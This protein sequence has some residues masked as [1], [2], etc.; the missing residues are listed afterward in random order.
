MVSQRFAGLAITPEDNGDTLLANPIVDQAALH[1][2]L[3]TVRDPGDA[4]GRGQRGRPGSA[5]A[6]NAD[7]TTPH[8]INTIDN[9]QQGEDAHVAQ[10]QHPR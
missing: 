10:Q 2:L 1:G 9:N 8:R 6:M 3:K 5:D 4:P 7:R